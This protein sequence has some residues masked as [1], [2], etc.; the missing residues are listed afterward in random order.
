MFSREESKKIRQDFWIFF[1]K[2]HPRKW[3]LYNTGIKDVALKFSFNSKQ[4][5]VSIDVASSDAVLKA[6]YFERLV[7]L[8]T[9]MLEEVSPDLIFDAHYRL[10]LGKEI[11]RIYISKDGVSIHNKESWPEVF[12]FFNTYM[13]KLERFYLEYKDFINS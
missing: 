6:Y 8:K 1:G 11:G 12:E 4:A 13:D 3:L 2:R 10:E 9:L 7:S 5:S